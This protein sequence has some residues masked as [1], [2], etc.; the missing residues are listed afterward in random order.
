MCY[1]LFLSQQWLLQTLP[2]KHKSNNLNT[3]NNTNLL[4]ARQYKQN[5]KQNYNI[6]LD[7]S[8]HIKQQK[9]NILEIVNLGEN[10]IA[11]QIMLEIKLKILK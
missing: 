11:Q 3:P 8:S 2:F 4:L 6:N 9:E 7:K 10:S 1:F 5:K